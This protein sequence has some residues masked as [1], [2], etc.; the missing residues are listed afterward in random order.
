MIIKEQLQTS[1]HPGA[2]RYRIRLELT[3][4]TLVDALIAGG[5]PTNFMYY[6]RVLDGLI[7]DQ[8]SRNR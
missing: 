7:V 1:L 6:C 3:T 5:T 8:V 2:D 4:Q